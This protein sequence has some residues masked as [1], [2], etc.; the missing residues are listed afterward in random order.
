MGKRLDVEAFCEGSSETRPPARQA[1]LDIGGE[2]AVSFTKLLKPVEVDGFGTLDFGNC[3]GTK[4]AVEDLGTRFTFHVP[5]NGA[6]E[7]CVHL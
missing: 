3:E 7:I 1:R 4:S 5:A 6:H 2:G